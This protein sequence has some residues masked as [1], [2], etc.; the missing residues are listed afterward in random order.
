MNNIKP[1]MY[2]E[3]HKP[4]YGTLQQNGNKYYLVDRMY[5][6]WNLISSLDMSSYCIL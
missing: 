4:I 5:R 2:C 3:L 1:M 6:K